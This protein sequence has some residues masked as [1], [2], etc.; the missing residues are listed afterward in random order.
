M[1]KFL[2]LSLTIFI[3]VE[4]TAQTYSDSLTIELTK[5]LNASDLPGFSVAI[6]NENGV[7]YQKGFGLANKEN[8]KQFDSSTILNLGSVSKTV[9]G[10]ALIKAI[11]D[12]KLTLDT[13]INDMLP[14]QVVNPFFKDKP[15]LIRHLANHTSSILDSKHYGKTYVLDE[16]FVENENT[17]QGFL[18]F[19]KSHAS[20]GLKDFLFNILN[21][22]GDWYRKK[23]FLKVKPGNKKEYSNL[24][25][26]LAAY[27][28]EIATEM[29]FEEYTQT[30]IFEPLGMQF[31]SWKIEEEKID[32]MATRYFPAGKQVPSYRLITY[33]DGGLYSNSTDLSKYLIEMIKAY[34]GNSTFL[35]LKYAKLLLPGDD[36]KN[37]A[38]WGIR[39]KNQTIG[40]EGSDPGTQ[41]D[42]RFKA[43]TKIGRII[44]INVN[45]E[46]SEVLYQQYRGIYDILAKYE[47]KLL[48]TVNR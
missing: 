9:V 33:P 42:M 40:H 19:L 4:L 31:T 24:N 30:K 34:S 13:K 12:G 21:K 22:D 20:I 14:F 25:A 15:I 23:N 17:H 8:R 29:P 10:L 47:N 38:F 1:K 32:R 44:L 45:A 3:S 27:I 18:G 36:D 26:A 43:D 2:I 28:I 46:D 41:A 35:P 6:V 37:R 5:H 39:E 48:D 16:N 11:E 7:L